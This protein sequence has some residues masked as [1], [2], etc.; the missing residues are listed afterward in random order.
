M[1][2]VTTTFLEKIKENNRHIQPYVVI[3]STGLDYNQVCEFSIDSSYGDSLPSIG[4]VVASTLKLKLVRGTPTPEIFTT[5]DIKP[6]IKLETSTGVRESIPLGVYKPKIDSIK[7]TNLTIEI[8]CMDAIGYSGEIPYNSTLTY[9]T[10]TT[11]VLQE[12][13]EQ[14]GMSI[15]IPSISATVKTAI[16]GSCRQALAE[17]AELLSCNAVV[18]RTGNVVFRYLNNTNFALDANNYMDFKLTSEDTIT[19]GKLRCKKT[20]EDAVDLTVGSNGFELSFENDNVTTT[21]ELQTIYNRIFPV[22]YYS[23]TL[24]CQG[25]PHLDVGDKISLTDN[26]GVTRNLYV[27]SHKLTFSGGLKSEFSAAAP[28]KDSSGTGS[29]GNTITGNLKEL[30][31]HKQIVEELIAGNITADNIKA[32]SIDATRLKTGTIT[33][34]SGVIANAA[35]KTAHIQDAAITSAKILD[36][37]ISNAKIGD[38]EIT[39]AKIANA[40]I[41][42]AKIEQGAI[43]TALI[44]TGAVGTAQIADGSITDA[45][46]VSL[47]A[48]KITAGTL[49]AG[50]I[51]VVN[52]NADNI[53]VG[54]INGQ[55]IADGAI[56]TEK[57]DDEAVDTS[58]IKK[59]AISTEL[60]SADAVTADKIVSGAV[61]TDKLAAKSVTANKIASN[62]V[63]ADKIAAN[64]I[65][66]DKIQAGAIT[67]DKVSSNFGASLDLNSNVAITSKVSKGD[68]IAEINL[69]EGN[70]KIAAGKIALEGFVSVNEKFSIDEAGFMNATGGTIA[71]FKIDSTSLSCDIAEDYS[72]LTSA[73][74]TKVQQ[75]ILG[76]V[77]LTDAEKEKYNI[78]GSYYIS[79]TDLLAIHRILTG[80]DPNYS[81]SKMSI[82]LNSARNA[83]LIEGLT[84]YKAGWKTRIG[85]GGFQGKFVNCERLTCNDISLA[86][87]YL[88]DYVVE[89]GTSGI[90]T[91]RKWNSGIAECWGKTSLQTISVTIA[92]AGL[93]YGNIPAV[94]LPFQ[95]VSVPFCYASAVDNGSNWSIQPSSG[96]SPT[97][98]RALYA[99]SPVYGTYSIAV[100]YLVIGRWK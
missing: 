9:P 30:N 63:T 54:T 50:E 69:S 24:T 43:T 83:I 3:G 88:D 95:F 38:A 5:Q 97:Q 62:A 89:Q 59:L 58:K 33:A 64:A 79:A 15:V 74:E 40:T 76:N 12:I 68:V 4:G 57:I 55:R 47:T 56:T 41:G 99:I 22:T 98:T 78:S 72:W 39:G 53:T 60:L 21:A 1:Y 100:E 32:N 23:Y 81:D 13:Q 80:A 31:I 27:L 49:D 51:N 6:Y 26:K 67:V 28:S 70:A 46:I 94:Y 35:I 61:T 73:D 7:K 8:D 71:G 36:G 25:M 52:L 42:T 85:A 75:A 82:N 34:D 66:A 2:N 77:T 45:K 29:T 19:I 14:S 90:W 48:N 10:T 11:A 20:G 84:G 65:T 18:D 44:D 93:Y 17:V 91:Y 96:G 86:G 92:W 16:T 87:G 37:A